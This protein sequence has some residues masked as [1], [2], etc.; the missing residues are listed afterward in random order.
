M[1]QLSS[2]NVLEHS[3]ATSEPELFS[4]SKHSQ[5]S[6]YDLSRIGERHEAEAVEEAHAAEPGLAASLEELYARLRAVASS[7]SAMDPTS[8]L[9]GEMERAA[10]TA[11]H[12]ALIECLA[13]AGMDEE[14]VHI[15]AGD[16]A[17]LQ[18]FT[19]PASMPHSSAP[20]IIN[21]GQLQIAPPFLFWKSA[22]DEC[23]GRKF[24]SP[25]ARLLF[26]HWS[27][28]ATVIWSISP[29]FHTT[30]FHIDSTDHISPQ[31]AFPHS[32][33]CRWQLTENIRDRSRTGTRTRVLASP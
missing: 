24:S 19:V 7:T 18:T 13:S 8:K 10:A 21:G 25:A 23:H 4:E 1:A 3:R 9:V 2:D 32:W 30:G 31:L 6:A 28:I 27:L 5:W 29:R 12:A 17:P 11:L 15:W 33:K 16:D 14:S 26:P 22:R 20:S